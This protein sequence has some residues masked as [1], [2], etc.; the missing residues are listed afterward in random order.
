MKTS[1]TE[2]LLINVTPALAGDTDKNLM[3]FRLLPNTK[4]YK[5]YKMNQCTVKTI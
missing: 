2:P 1:V 5:N 3:Q 4:H